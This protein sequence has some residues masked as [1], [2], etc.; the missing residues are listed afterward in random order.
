[1]AT[2]R[3][4]VGGPIPWNG[5]DMWTN[6]DAWQPRG[7]PEAGDE[8]TLEA[9]THFQFGQTGFPIVLHAPTGCIY[10]PGRRAAFVPEERR[11]REDDGA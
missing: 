10:E 7:I 9:G 8:L 4:Y 2:K 6:P 3:V 5:G 1:M 11:E